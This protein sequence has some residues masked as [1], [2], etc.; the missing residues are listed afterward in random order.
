M[1]AIFQ[2]YILVFYCC[3]K[4]EELYR[5]QLAKQEQREEGLAFENTKLKQLLNEVTQDL[6]EMLATD[7][8]SARVRVS[9]GYF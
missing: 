8:G 7:G 2:L 3:R 1:L 9:W 6:E 4:E 5:I